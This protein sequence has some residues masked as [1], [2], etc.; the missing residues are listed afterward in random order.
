M[1]AVR[2]IS[3]NEKFTYDDY[4][5]WKDNENWELLEG[6]AYAMAPSPYRAHQEIASKIHGEIYQFLKGK[7]CKVFYEW[8]VV[9]SDDTVVKPDIFI[10]CDKKKITERNLQGAPDFV[11]EILSPQTKKRDKG[12]KLEAY[13][14]YGVKEYWIVDPLYKEIE[15]Y[16]FEEKTSEI[17][18]H[19]CDEEMLKNDFIPVGIFGDKLKLD[20]KYIFEE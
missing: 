14:K 12:I 10:V 3:A 13:R 15:V 11:V 5:L 1:T 20:L 2:K 6:T 16:Y 9:L 7:P 19:E 17:F 8:D 4:K 18:S